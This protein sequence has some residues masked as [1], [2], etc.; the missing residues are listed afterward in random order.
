MGSRLTLLLVPWFT[1]RHHVSARRPSDG[2]SVL[3]SSVRIYAYT[4]DCQSALVSVTVT[5]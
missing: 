3:K 2:P 5:T 4:L 1:S